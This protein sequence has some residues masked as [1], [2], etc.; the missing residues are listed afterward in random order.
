MRERSV[1]ENVGFAQFQF[2]T[3]WE[4]IGTGEPVAG[5]NIQV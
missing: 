1:W 3:N 5:R 2:E 4:E